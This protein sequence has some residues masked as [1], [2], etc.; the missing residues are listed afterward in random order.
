MRESDRRHAAQCRQDTIP[1]CFAPR[2]VAIADRMQE[3]QRPV[4][5]RLLFRRQGSEHI[6]AEAPEFR[7]NRQ[8]DVFVG[9]EPGYQATSFS[10]I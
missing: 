1:T 4:R 7:N 3:R 6:V 9:I 2:D 10:R 8:S 5:M